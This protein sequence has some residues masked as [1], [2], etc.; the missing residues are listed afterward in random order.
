METGLEAATSNR[1]IN[2]HNDA[3]K[4]LVQA[5]FLSMQPAG[6]LQRDTTR[7]T[8]EAAIGIERCRAA[9]NKRTAA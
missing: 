7:C 2:A 6:L 1:T 4:T 8:R 3:A 9:D 5:F